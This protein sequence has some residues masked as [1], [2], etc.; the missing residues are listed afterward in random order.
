M[1]TR[2]EVMEA[3]A[4]KMREH[5][6]QMMQAGAEFEARSA[7]IARAKG[8]DAATVRTLKDQDQV[9]GDAYKTWSYHAECVRTYSALIV[10]ESAMVQ[11]QAVPRAQ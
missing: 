7:E 11:M 4:V 8:P 5:Y 9:R 1:A 2:R 10:A 6:A 3:W